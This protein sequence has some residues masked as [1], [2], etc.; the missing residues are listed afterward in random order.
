[1]GDFGNF[2]SNYAWI[3]LILLVEILLLGLLAIGWLQLRKRWKVISQ[4]RYTTISPE[5]TRSLQ[6]LVDQASQDRIETLNIVLG[7]GAY[8]VEKTLNVDTPIQLFGKGVNETVVVA[9]SHEAA[10]R[11]ENSKQCSVKNLRVEGAIQCHNSELLLENCHIL[12][13]DDGICI[14][15]D[16]GSEVT[17]SGVMRG[18]GGIAIR[19]RGESKVILKPPYAVSGEDYVVKDPRS[20]VE[21]HLD[22]SPDDASPLQARQA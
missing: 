6:A 13:G 17:F 12:A 15:A 7:E 4:E 16:Q 19:A 9:P 3:G 21:V 11:F 8:N 18:D 22:Q 1:M 20:H 5:N 10:L 14:E 2:S